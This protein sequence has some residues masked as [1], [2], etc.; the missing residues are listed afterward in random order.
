MKSDVLGSD[1]SLSPPP[2]YGTLGELFLLSVPQIP[3]CKMGTLLVTNYLTENCG[4][5]LNGHFTRKHIQMA[6]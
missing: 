2:T 5:R 3:Q 1:P 4:K 6:K